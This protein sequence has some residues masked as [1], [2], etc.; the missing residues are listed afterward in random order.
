MTVHHYRV[1]APHVSQYPEPITFSAGAVL[2]VGE[3]YDGPEGWNDWFFCQ[4]PGQPGGWVSGQVI[5]PGSPK[6]GSESSFPA[7]DFP[8]GFWRGDIS[9]LTPAFGLEDNTAREHSANAGD[10]VTG[11]RRL[12]GWLWA[13]KQATSESGWVPLAHLEQIS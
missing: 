13:D 1:T 3:R 7:S 12:N 4:T 11:S 10:V 5:G 8:A 2:A 6:P 9:K